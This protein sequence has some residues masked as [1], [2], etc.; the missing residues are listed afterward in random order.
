[1]RG[2]QYIKV[3]DIGSF[4]GGIHPAQHKGES[5]TTPIATC[6]YRIGFGCR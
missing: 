2:S 6:R 3:I 4:P 5:N 1:M